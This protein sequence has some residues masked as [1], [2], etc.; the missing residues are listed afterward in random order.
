MPVLFQDILFPPDISF[1]AVGGPQFK[2]TVVRSKSGY[3]Q[4][5]IEWE[6]VKGKYDV[7]HGLKTQEQI[8]DLL[9][10]FMS[11]QGQAHSFRFLDWV[12]YTI[13]DQEVGPGDNVETDFQIIK[14]HTDAG[15]NTFDKNITKPVDVTDTNHTLGY[16][17][18]PTYTT[19]LVKVNGVTKTEGV[20]YTVNYSTGVITF[21]VA[22]PNTHTVRVWCSFHLHGVF[23]TDY[24]PVGIDFHEIHNWG[25]IPIE[26]LKE[27]G[28]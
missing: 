3:T 21:A 12:N 14:T 18:Y 5:N 27:T 22:P 1:G 16:T 10:F 15:G 25:P 7:T 2:T 17:D 20:D 8:D 6:L 9:A 4:R 19:M 24:M 26:E 23:T 13:E 11:K 28:V